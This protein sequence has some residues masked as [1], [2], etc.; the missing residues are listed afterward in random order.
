MNDRDSALE[1]QQ[2]SILKKRRKRSKGS[3]R[4]RTTS[5][6]EENEEEDTSA[7]LE[8]VQ[9]LQKARARRSDV[10]LNAVNGAK[11]L[12]QTSSDSKDSRKFL[13]DFSVELVNDATKKDMDTFV[14]SELRKRRT[15]ESGGSVKSGDQKKTDKK[16]TLSSDLFQIPSKY[17]ER[18]KFE[19][20]EASS[21][22]WLAGITE[23][24]LPVEVKMDNIQR[25]EQAKK[26]LL[27]ED[28]KPTSSL[29]IPGNYNSNFA[30][31]HNEHLAKLEEKK[32]C[33]ERERR[34]IEMNAAARGEIRFN[35][36]RKRLRDRA[37][38]EKKAKRM[39]TDDKMLDR[40]INRH[41]RY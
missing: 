28:D 38:E 37:A 31:H 39:A 20:G 12:N 10:L 35:V 40:F 5:A 25:T 8:E 33:E 2:R 3:T 18:V 27:E 29:E 11:E 17:K 19:S 23:V 34:D 30:L 9:M 32:L 16:A 22:Q 15:K 6:V 7:L 21:D 41:Q 1:T 14:K 13:G 26:T 4:K 24:E 36:Q